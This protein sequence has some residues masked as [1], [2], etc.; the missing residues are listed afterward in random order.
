MSK[1]ILVPASVIDGIPLAP[2]SFPVEGVE[3]AHR[4]FYSIEK[5]FEFARPAIGAMFA[6][7][8]GQNYKQHKTKGFP[9]GCVFLEDGFELKF[10]DYII[11]QGDGKWSW[12]HGGNLV[13]H[14]ERKAIADAEEAK[15]L[16]IESMPALS[17]LPTEM[18][19]Y[20]HHEGIS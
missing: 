7:F 18:R 15:R 12:L 16:Q 3:G 6:N 8:S 10:N 11:Y 13:S 14:M 4:F 19:K 2:P 20:F 17:H 1:N 5:F 9:Y